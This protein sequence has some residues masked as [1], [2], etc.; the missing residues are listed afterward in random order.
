MG[1]V[2][3]KSGAVGGD[4][5]RL[6]DGGSVAGLGDGELL[7]RFVDRGDGAA[8]EA[9]VGRL[10][11]MV[12][13]VCR[14]ILGD[15]HDVDDA[16]QATFLVLV[17]R[18]GS[19]RERDLVGPWLH[20]VAARVARRARSESARRAA[21]E[22]AS[23]VP[24]AREG[25][26]GPDPDGSG[27]RALIDEE[28]GRLPE[29]HRRPVVL[30]DVEGLSREE[31]ARRLGWTPNMVRGRLE[32]ARGRL[33]DRL[34]RRGL[35]PSGPWSVLLAARSVPSPALVAAT[36]RA[37]LSFGVG[38]I[39][40][41]LA[42]ASAVALSRGVLT[43][44]M[45]SK[46]KVAAAVALAAGFVAAGSGML[47]AQGPA[48]PPAPQAVAPVAPPRGATDTDALAVLG[49][50]RVEMARE[51]Y[52]TQRN[53][54]EQ[55]RITIDRI[56][57]ASQAL[58]DAEID[59]TG[60]PAARLAAI[61]AHLGRIKQIE[62]RE[63]AELELGRATAA[64]IVEIQT[65]RLDT[66][67]RLAKEAAVAE[68]RPSTVADLERRVSEVEKKVDRVLNLLNPATR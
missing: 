31:A 35:A 27:L 65:G 64:D 57:G 30:C 4:L 21:R 46:L 16:F 49:R 50:S 38:R 60:E 39:G 10:G 6:L 54:Y 12:L 55:G 2:G 52:K 34:A 23:V 48:T 25:E 26:T 41:S 14:R 62:A 37:A 66:E 11:P 13:G 43:M 24:E 67:Y 15:S 45:L 42:S 61:R 19:I 29:H 40:S 18:A 47:G 58:M 3:G 17:R 68:A 56:L 63:Q 7:G 9:L 8:F 5:L 36:G 44:M 53:F 59:A 33:R 28:I 20:G 51:R 22:R 32:R 1:R